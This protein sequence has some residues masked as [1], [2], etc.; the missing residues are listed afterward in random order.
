MHKSKFMECSNVQRFM[1]V[2]RGRCLQECSLWAYNAV[3]GV[4]NSN[5]EA[6]RPDMCAPRR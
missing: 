6:G 4:I 3:N 2:Y 5:K 1:S